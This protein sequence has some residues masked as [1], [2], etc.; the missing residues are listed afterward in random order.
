MYFI[1]YYIDDRNIKLLENIKMLRMLT[2][3]I[4]TP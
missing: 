2:T 4:P 1:Y 3:N